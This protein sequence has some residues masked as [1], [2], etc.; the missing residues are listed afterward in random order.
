MTFRLMCATSL[1]V[2]LIGVDA[3]LMKARLVNELPGH[4]VELTELSQIRGEA[5]KALC[6]QGAPCTGGGVAVA[7]GNPVDQACASEGSQCTVCT[8]GNNQTCGVGTYV[9]PVLPPVLCCAPTH[10][11]WV[12]PVVGQPPEGTCNCSKAGVNGGARAV[13]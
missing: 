3:A 1:F 9:C 4:V 2:G 12:A 11:K 6:V 5:P 7:C 13:C 8:G 10:C